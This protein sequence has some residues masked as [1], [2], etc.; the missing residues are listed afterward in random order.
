MRLTLPYNDNIVDGFLEFAE[1]VMCSQNLASLSCV[2]I[3][4]SARWFINCCILTNL[5]AMSS[6]LN[7]IY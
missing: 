3:T 6:I 1:S 5:I 4:K 2:P 7:P